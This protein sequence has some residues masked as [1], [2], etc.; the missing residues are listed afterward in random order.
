MKQENTYLKNNL[1]AKRKTSKAN[2]QAKCEVVRNRLLN[3]RVKIR[4]V[5]CLSFKNDS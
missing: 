3:N 1:E 5:K 4:N 2:Y